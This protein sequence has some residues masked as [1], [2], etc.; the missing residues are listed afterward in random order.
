M[1]PGRRV[2]GLAEVAG[3]AVLLVPAIVGAA[4]LGRRLV[5]DPVEAPPAGEPT[6]V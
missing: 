3:A 5:L 2:S 1:S 4:V 6:A